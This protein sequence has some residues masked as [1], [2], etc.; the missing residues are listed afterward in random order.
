MIE[1]ELEPIVYCTL[2]KYVDTIPELESS[3][4][5]FMHATRLFNNREANLEKIYKLITAGG[6]TTNNTN[7]DMML[8]VTIMGYELT[9]FKIE[10]TADDRKHLIVSLINGSYE[11][12]LRA[13]QF[14]TTNYLS[15]NRY[16]E[17]SVKRWTDV[18]NALGQHTVTPELLDLYDQFIKKND[19]FGGLATGI[20]EACYENFE[21]AK[22][23]VE[24]RQ[25]NVPQIEGWLM[26]NIAD[27][28]DDG[29]SAIQLSYAAVILAVAIILQ[30]FCLF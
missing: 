18:F 13:I 27:V 17:S 11:S 4:S 3:G 30:N 25:A 28:E 19:Q 7:I 26:R 15:L 1:E 21:K 8:D 12:T 2:A 6:C 10:L 24:W 23:N 16:F 5:I 20:R 29:A 14:I 9:L 22:K